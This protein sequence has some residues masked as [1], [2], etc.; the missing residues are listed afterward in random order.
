MDRLCAEVGV[1]DTITTF[2]VRRCVYFAFF[3]KPARPGP[4]EDEN[5]RETPGDRD[6]P[7]LSP[8]FVGEDGTFR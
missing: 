1:A 4:A 5:T 6:I 7:P 3:R 2:Y 8:L